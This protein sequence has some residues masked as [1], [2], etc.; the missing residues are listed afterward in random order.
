[1]LGQCLLESRLVAI[2]NSVPKLSF[3]HESLSHCGAV[4]CWRLALVS[5]CWLTGSCQQSTVWHCSH[6]N[7]LHLPPL[8][9][10]QPPA[11]PPAPSP[12]PCPGGGGAVVLLVWSWAASRQSEPVNNQH[13]LKWELQLVWKKAPASGEWRSG[14]EW[15]GVTT[16]DFSC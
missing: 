11:P 5:H 6:I 13:Q 10:H 2:F 15:S 4:D 7:T 3:I 12:T 8:T 9:S 16:N 1:M 14:V